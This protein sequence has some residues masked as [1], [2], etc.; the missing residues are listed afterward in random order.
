VTS[1]ALL[2]GWVAVATVFVLLLA[3]ELA[4]WRALSS[5][6]GRVSAER[7]RL[8]D[9]IR[10]RDAQLAAE[11]RTHGAR[12][13]EMQAAG[14]GAVDPSA[15]LRRLGE[16]AREKK[17]KVTAVGPLERQSTQQFTKSWHTVLVVGPY[18]EIRDLAARVE[19]D[20]GLLEDVRL[21]VAPPSPTASPETPAGGDVQARF[22]LTALELSPDARRLVDRALAAGGRV[23]GEGA[24]GLPAGAPPDVAERALARD[25]FAFPPGRAVAAGPGQSPA[26]EKPLAP[27]VLTAIVS[28]PGGYLAVVNNQIVKVGDTVGGARVEKITETSVSLREPGASPRVIELPELGGPPPPAPRR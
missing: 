7:R 9:E 22:R 23:G 26:P 28:F 6:D 10:L 11:L 24:P 17:L 19:R 14:A 13:A 1:R 3:W 5:E 25:P 2:A 16:L 15:F 12:L 27:M 8:T 21:E 18:R 4:Q 20:K